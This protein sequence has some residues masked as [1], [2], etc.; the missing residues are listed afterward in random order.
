[1]IDK[2]AICPFCG[3]DAE[4]RKDKVKFEYMGIKKNVVPKKRWFCPNCKQFFKDPASKEDFD[5]GEEKEKIEN[6]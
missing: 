5:Y 3:S 2:T 1:M 4:Q 6:V